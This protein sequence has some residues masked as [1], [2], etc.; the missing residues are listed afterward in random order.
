MIFKKKIDLMVKNILFYLFNFIIEVDLIFGRNP[1]I[2]SVD[3]R[4]VNT[5]AHLCL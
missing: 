3:L 1:K 2:R 5:S 4:D